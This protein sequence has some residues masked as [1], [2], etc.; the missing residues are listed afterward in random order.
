VNHNVISQEM[1]PPQALATCA[2]ALR[3]LKQFAAVDPVPIDF[4][5]GRSSE[6]KAAGHYCQIC[7][8]DIGSCAIRPQLQELADQSRPIFDDHTAQPRGRIVTSL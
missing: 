4:Y 2:R 7:P 1:K 5:H 6:P 8:V 3:E